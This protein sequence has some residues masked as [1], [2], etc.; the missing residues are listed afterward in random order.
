ME[1]M[2]LLYSLDIM[3]PIE[4]TTF[5]A[6]LKF[7]KAGEKTFPVP[8]S[9]NKSLFKDESCYVYEEKKKDQYNPPRKKDKQIW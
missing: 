4:S 5:Y 1:F 6:S 3:G 7:D 8:S 9:I 2:C